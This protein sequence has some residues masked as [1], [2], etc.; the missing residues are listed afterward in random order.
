MKRQLVILC[1]AVFTI[2]PLAHRGLVAWWDVSPWKLFGWAMFCVPSPRYFGVLAEVRANDTVNHPAFMDAAAA[3]EPERFARTDHIAKHRYL[4]H[5]SH[6]GRLADQ[7]G[8]AR[9]ILDR[10][11]EMGSI[12]FAVNRA[13]MERR[14]ASMQWRI[15][16]TVHDRS[17]IPRKYPAQVLRG[18]AVTPVQ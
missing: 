14:S 5:R 7:R 1:L 11:P 4:F 2:W 13:G 17:G 15:E 10:H 3:A 8:A 6:L 18:P 9:Q 16:T 12:A